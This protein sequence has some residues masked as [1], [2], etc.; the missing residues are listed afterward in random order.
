[1]FSK[2][3]L[4]KKESPVRS[5]TAKTLCREQSSIRRY[6]SQKPISRRRP[7]S[8]PSFGIR[9]RRSLVPGRAPYAVRNWRG[10]SCHAGSVGLL[11][12]WSRRHESISRIII[13]RLWSSF[14]GHRFSRFGLAVVL[15][16]SGGLPLAW[17]FGCT[18]DPSVLPLLVAGLAGSQSVGIF[19]LVIPDCRSVVSGRRCLVSSGSPHS[20]KA[21]ASFPSGS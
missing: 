2:E 17:S 18:P 12:M 10:S 4:R 19:K 13:P 14:D 8:C 20:W 11:E 6:G 15:F 5:P 1:M 7:Q 3:C 9:L 21:H 16:A